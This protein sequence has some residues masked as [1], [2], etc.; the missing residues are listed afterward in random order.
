[1]L[2][3]EA[4]E[5]SVQGTHFSFRSAG[6]GEVALLTFADGNSLPFSGPPRQL[7]R[8]FSPHDTIRFP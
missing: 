6:F 4:I 3:A 2:R 1:M 7:F 8:D 5:Y